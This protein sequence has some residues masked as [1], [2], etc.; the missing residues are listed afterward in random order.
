MDRRLPKLKL[1]AWGSA[2]FRPLF[3]GGTGGGT[4][5]WAAPRDD[6]LGGGGGADPE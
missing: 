1:A 5:G 3:L 4:G 2:F 6:R